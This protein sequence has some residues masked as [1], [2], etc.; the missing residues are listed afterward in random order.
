MYETREPITGLSTHISRHGS[1]NDEGVV[2]NLWVRRNDFYPHSQLSTAIFD[3]AVF[4][5]KLLITARC[6]DVDF[7]IGVICVG[8]MQFKV[9]SDGF[10]ALKI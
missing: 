10:F 8:N 1:E 7:P 4:C 3:P 6:R 2:S 9:D 5:S